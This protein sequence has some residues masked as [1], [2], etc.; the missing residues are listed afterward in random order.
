[1]KQF[2]DLFPNKLENI[3]PGCQRFQ[4]T[5]NT[6]TWVKRDK[7]CQFSSLDMVFVFK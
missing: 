3:V 2:E 7:S 6:V 4:E 5:K 1:M